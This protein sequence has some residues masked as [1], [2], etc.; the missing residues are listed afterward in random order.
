MVF[1]QVQGVLWG[2]AGDWCTEQQSKEGWEPPRHAGS[3]IG[4]QEVGAVTPPTRPPLPDPMKKQV[5]CMRPMKSSRP[6]MA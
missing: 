6:M 2:G 5:L 3:K 4:V 1:G